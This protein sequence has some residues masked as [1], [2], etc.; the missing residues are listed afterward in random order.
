MSRIGKKPIEIPKGV[1]VKLEGLNVTVKGAKGE[2]S[3]TCPSEIKISVVDGRV[4]LERIN[5]EKNVRS[6]HGLTRSLLSNM[7]DGVS[8]GYQ[9]VLDIAGTGYRAQVQGEK[10]ILALGFSTPVEFQLPKGIKAAVDQKQT[11]LTL[12]GFDKQ[13]IGQVA[14][15][16][17]G[18]RPPDA[19]KGK[20]VRYSG[21]RIKLK[22]G[23]A[24]KK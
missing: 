7:I 5:E 21:E 4:V 12:T 6:L 16:L 13:L 2:I 10:I 15:N 11:Q 14:A 3:A 24:G 22:V 20:G 23:K 8:S 1:D 17:R 19:Y 18:I 9:R